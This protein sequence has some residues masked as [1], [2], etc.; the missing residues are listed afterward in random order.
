MYVVFSSPISSLTTFKAL[1]YVNSKLSFLSQ[2]Q[3]RG[4]IFQQHPLKFNS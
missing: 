3:S 1:N 4:S 2:F